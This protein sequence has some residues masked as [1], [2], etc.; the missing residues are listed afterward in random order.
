MS[1]IWQSLKDILAMYLT[2]KTFGNP[3]GWYLISLI[4]IITTTKKGV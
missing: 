1:E 3:L 4:H 2:Y